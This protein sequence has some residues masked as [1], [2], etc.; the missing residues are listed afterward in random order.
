MHSA[1]LTRL[2]FQSAEAGSLGFRSEISRNQVTL[3]RELDLY[4]SWFHGTPGLHIGLSHES[5]ISISDG[6]ILFPVSYKSL[7][8]SKS[9][10][11]QAGNPF[12]HGASPQNRLWSASATNLFDLVE[13]EDGVEEVG[14]SFFFP[15]KLCSSFKS[16]FCSQFG[17]SHLTLTGPKVA[18]GSHRRI[19][20]TA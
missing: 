6:Q 15:N 3:P 10:G 11:L 9:H 13:G 18:L 12:S 14:R 5:L 2:L 7:P 17:P 20:S 1:I 16:S 19:V 8:S 4:I